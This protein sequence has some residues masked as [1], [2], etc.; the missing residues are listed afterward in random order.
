M[1][2]GQWTYC[3]L[4]EDKETKEDKEDKETKVDKE[5]KDTKVDCDDGSAYI[6][7][8]VEGQGDCCRA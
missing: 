6:L 1:D 2:N 3:Y 7:I 4:Q 8:D 5:D